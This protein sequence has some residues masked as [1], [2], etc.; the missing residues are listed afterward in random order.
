ME[1]VKHRMNAGKEGGVFFFRDSN[2]NEVDL[3][4]KEEG[5]IRAYEVKSS[6]TYTTEFEKTIKKLPEWL[7][8]PIVSKSIIYAGSLEN[9]AAD[10]KLINYKNLTF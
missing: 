2:Q 3:L 4:L 8:T 10:V 5:E 7:T 9:S 1:A 6:M